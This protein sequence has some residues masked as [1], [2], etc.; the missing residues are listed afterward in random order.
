MSGKVFIKTE[1]ISFKS[2]AVVKGEVPES[3]VLEGL[4]RNNTG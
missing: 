3:E 1:D 4:V 2:E